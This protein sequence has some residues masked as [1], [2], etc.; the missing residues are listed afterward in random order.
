MQV[1]PECKQQRYQE[2]CC[3]KACG[4]RE[5]PRKQQAEDWKHCELGA[6]NGQFV[7]IDKVEAGDG[8]ESGEG[9]AADMNSSEANDEDAEGREECSGELEPC[10]SSGLFDG[11][12]CNFGEPWQVNHADA[13][14]DGKEWF[15]AG[16]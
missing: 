10:E 4:A 12:E 8:Q 14:A 5:D 11:G 3:T 13:F 7:S 9:R 16:D 6:K 2:P 1:G 15:S